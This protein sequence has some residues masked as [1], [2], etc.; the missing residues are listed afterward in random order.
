MKYIID[1]TVKITSF[2]L[3][4]C[5]QGKLEEPQKQTIIQFIQ[6]GVV[7]VSNTFVAYAIYVLALGLMRKY[8]AFIRSDY[9]VAQIISWVLSVAW[10]FYW[11]NKCVFNGEED[12]DKGK[13]VILW[14][15]ILKTYASYAFT[16]V[17]LNT[18]LSILWVDGLGISKLFAP[19][20]NL[21]VSVPLNFILN[22]FWAF[23]KCEYLD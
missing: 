5:L 13:D 8:D 1:S 22:K 20:I 6:F 2:I 10:S 14:K 23:K 9:L 15:A 11:N 16:G 17:F 12:V 4:K 3:E 21:V 19:I 18:V 7:G